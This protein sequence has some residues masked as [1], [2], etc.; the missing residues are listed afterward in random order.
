MGQAGA[1]M[2]LVE[3]GKEVRQP[4]AAVACYGNRHDSIL[5]RSRRPSL[6]TGRLCALRLLVPLNCGGES[7]RHGGARMEPEIALGAGD[8][9]AAPRLAIR[10]AGIPYDAAI[11][12]AQAGERVK[13]TCKSS[14]LTQRQHFLRFRLRCGLFIEQVGNIGP[15]AHVQ[16]L[17]DPF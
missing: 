1:I 4:R 8:I 16:A 9:E 13:S 3:R 15:T 5:P 6:L 12:T 14:L 17:G 2:Y 11:I 7:L 10:L